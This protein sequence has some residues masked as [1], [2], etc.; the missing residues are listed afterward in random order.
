MIGTRKPHSP[1]HSTSVLFDIRVIL[2]S[3]DA[4]I[5]PGKRYEDWD[6]PGPAGLDRAAV[7]PVRDQIHRACSL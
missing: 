5:Y 6:L 4:P 2:S 1:P 3:G 7:R